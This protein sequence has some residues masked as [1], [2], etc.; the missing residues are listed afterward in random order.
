MKKQLHFLLLALLVSFGHAAQKS[1]KVSSNALLTFNSYAKAYLVLDD[2]TGYY[3]YTLSQKKWVRHPMQAILELPFADFKARFIPISIDSDKYYFVQ[4]GCGLVYE[5]SKGV[6][7]RIDNSYDQKNQFE[8]AVY[9][10]RHKVYMF[11]GYGLFEVKNTHTYYEPLDKEWFQVEHFSEEQPPK[12]TNAFRIKQGDD[13]YILG[14]YQLNFNK[15]KR[16]NDIWRFDMRRKTWEQLGE[17]SPDIINRLRTRG[18]VP[19]K[20]YSIFTYNDKLT[21]VQ[22]LANKY[23]TFKSPVYWNV[24]RVVPSF[25]RKYLLVSRHNSNDQNV[26]KLTVQPLSKMLIGVPKEN[27]LYKPLSL[28]KKISY[29]TYLWISLI[30]NLVFFFL[31]FYVQRITKTKWYKP[32]KPVLLKNEF[33]EMEWEILLKIKQHDE[34]ELSS[35]NDY[36]NENGLSFETLKK[37]RESFIRALRIKLALYTRRDIEDLLVESKHPLDKRMKIIKWN[38]DIQMES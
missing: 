10:F 26:V 32:K 15:N 18:F 29:D 38:S 27:Y 25:D 2:S 8:A 28:F 6:L 36:F 11:G 22:L 1:I 30:L 24:N 17:L 23:Y 14:G 19:N 16:L 4:N 9:E 33:S 21:M 35:L 20:D 31:L 37:R 34:L 3:T 12:R 5:L 13:L 7:R